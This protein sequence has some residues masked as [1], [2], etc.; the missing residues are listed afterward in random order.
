MA[1]R[2]A[3]P[4]CRASGLAQFIPRTAEWISGIYPNELGERA[5]N[6][7]WAIRA[8]VRATTCGC[9]SACRCRTAAGVCGSCCG[10]TTA[11][12]GYVLKEFKASGSCDPAQV[13]QQCGSSVRRLRAAK[14]S[15]TRVGS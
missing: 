3:V 11:A 8:L 14:T 5:Y 6:P 12:W 7:T 2:C 15:I 10:P 4:C 1:G 9:G 13:G